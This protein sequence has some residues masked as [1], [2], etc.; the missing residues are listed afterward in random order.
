MLAESLA[1]TGQQWT[2]DSTDSVRDSRF[3]AP[4]QPVKADGCVGWLLSP[5]PPT[6]LGSTLRRRCAVKLRRV[7][8][9]L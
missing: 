2:R 6:P 5:P 1:K 3:V 7:Y 4:G 8:V 9:Q